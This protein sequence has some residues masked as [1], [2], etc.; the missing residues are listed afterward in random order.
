MDMEGYEPKGEGQ[1]EEGDSPLVVRL[2]FRA[3]SGEE[4]NDFQTPEDEDTAE[5]LCAIG[6]GHIESGRWGPFAL[7]CSSCSNY[8]LDANVIMR[9]G[10]GIR[11]LS[12]RST[13]VTGSNQIA[14]DFLF[15]VAFL[16]SFLTAEPASTELLMI[17]ANNIC[18]CR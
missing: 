2:E 9:A 8:W 10:I 13:Q 4:E 3:A 12:K 7:T 1:V 16:C 17:F 15:R 5:V 6:D 14:K 11:G 18:I